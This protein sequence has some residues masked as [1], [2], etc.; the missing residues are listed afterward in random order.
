MNIY[1]TIVIVAVI[2]LLG[3]VIKQ[4]LIIIKEQSLL[5]KSENI[6]EYKQAIEQKE[7]QEEE[8][9]RYKDVRELTPEQIANVSRHI[10]IDKIYS[11]IWAI[12]NKEN[13]N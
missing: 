6:I 10:D 7:E 12:D 9:E 5:I 1:W 13:F 4:L 2:V 3:F 11:W 8:N